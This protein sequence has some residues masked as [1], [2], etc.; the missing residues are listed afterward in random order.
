[1]SSGKTTLALQTAYNL[2]KSGKLVLR[3]TMLDRSGPGQMTSRLG[4]SE[5]AYEIRKDDDL[6]ELHRKTN[7]GTWVI[8]EAQFLSTEQVEQIS[9]LADDGL[10]AYCFG[11]L[12]DFRTKMFPGSRR[13]A[14]LADEVTRITL[15]TPC[16]CGQPGQ[17]NARIVDNELVKDGDQ[18][19]IGDIDGGQVA[20]KVLC[21]KHWRGGRHDQ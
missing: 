21:R 7:T 16:W 10:D 2:E 19:V 1:M 13:L 4:I 12:T 6:L 18:V 15:V 9:V 20:Y 11:L 5:T 17:V 3:C 14:E 8:D